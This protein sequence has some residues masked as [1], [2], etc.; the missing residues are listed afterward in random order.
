[1]ISPQFTVC[2]PAA[3]SG[4]RMHTNEPKQY[5][6]LHNVPLIVHT[7]RIFDSISECEQIIIAADKVAAMYDVVKPD[8]FQKNIIIVSGGA[9]RQQSV[10]NCLKKIRTDT[11]V[12]IHDA[13]R[14]CVTEEE[15]RDVVEAIK[16]D[17]A[18][19]LAIPA[20]DTVKK[21]NKKKMVTRTIPRQEIYLAQTPQGAYSTVLKNAYQESLEAGVEFTDDVQV[22]ERKGI[23]I[24]VVE[25]KPTNIKIT[26]KEDIIIA[27]AI[28]KRRSHS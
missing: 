15:I 7:V 19:V 28:L 20:H 9:T 18:A 16:K 26:T 8:S 21:V 3:G 11:I 10:M 5:L 25:G 4:S 17:G 1:M 13:A 24:R 22:L 6:F 23:P 2:I 14:P 12:L 27:E